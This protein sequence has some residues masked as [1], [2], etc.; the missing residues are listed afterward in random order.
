MSRLLRE[1]IQP[2]S[3]IRKWPRARREQRRP[4]EFTETITV[5]TDAAMSPR[6]AGY[7]AGEEIMRQINL[8][9]PRGYFY[10]RGPFTT[11]WDP[12]TDERVSEVS[13]TYK[14]KEPQNP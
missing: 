1:K 12:D 9:C 14:R 8:R 2:S 13:V 10:R 5:R 3:F 4:D 6:V 11:V 7:A